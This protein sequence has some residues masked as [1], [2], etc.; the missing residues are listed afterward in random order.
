MKNPCVA[1]FA[2]ISAITTR[3][4]SIYRWKRMR[5]IPVQF[6]RLGKSSRHLKSAGCTTGTSVERPET[7]F[8][9]L[10]G[11]AFSTTGL[12]Q[13]AAAI[14][15]ELTQK[16]RSSVASTIENRHTLNGLVSRQSQCANSVVDDI[17]GKDNTS[18]WQA[19]ACDSE[20]VLPHHITIETRMAA[21]P[22]ITR[23]VIVGP[24]ARA[25]CAEK[26]ALL[27][28]CYEAHM[29]RPYNQVTRL[30]GTDTLKLRNAGKDLE[31]GRIWIS[32]PGSR[33]YLM[34]QVR[35]VELLTL[36]RKLEREIKERLALLASK[37]AGSGL[38]RES[39]GTL[40]RSKNTL[41]REQEGERQR[42]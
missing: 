18:K 21:P 15:S 20:R 24:D 32:Q 27:V 17:I 8:D 36:R 2:P 1:R 7:N 28:V 41:G 34:D 25:G 35:A 6:N 4:V 13:R 10:T 38:H 11:S 12:K 14:V 42:C 33:Q 26:C 9:P 5:P 23:I 19:L 37:Q 3:L 39:S 40:L 16:S 29:P 31:G 30:R 22:P